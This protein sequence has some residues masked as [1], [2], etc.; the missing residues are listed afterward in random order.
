MN[1]KIEML[2][3]GA[4][5][6]SIDKVHESRVVIENGE[7]KTIFSEEI[8]RTGWMSIDEFRRLGHEMI[9]K[10]RELLKQKNQKVH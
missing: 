5:H 1:K 4:A 6:V 3:L 2:A 10:T 8:Q 7:V 9:D